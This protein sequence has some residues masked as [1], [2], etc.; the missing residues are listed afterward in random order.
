MQRILLV[1]GGSGGHV[2]PVIAVA[3][4]LKER[5]A[6]AGGLDLALLGD[7]NFMRQAAQ[8]NGIKFRSILAGKLRRYFSLLAVLDIFKFPIGF[9]QSLWH[10]F[11]FMP[12]AVFAKGGYVSIMPALVARLYFI[13]LY[14]HES[15]SVPG[16]ANKFLGRLADKIFKTFQISA[17]YFDQKKT[18]LFGNPVRRELLG[19]NKDE[20]AK[21]FNLSTGKKTIFVYGGSQGAQK[22]NNAIL[23]SLV[24]AVGK[25]LQIIHQCGDTQYQD[26]K[27]SIE[28][29]I[30]EGEGQY[31]ELI[32]RNHRLYSFLNLEQARSAYALADV[33]ISRAGA[34]NIF[35]IASVGK[36]AIIIP[37]VDTSGDHQL[38]NAIAFSKSGAVLIE[39]DNLTPHIILSQI[40][41][42]FIPD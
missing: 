16:L 25:D 30:K 36:P 38:N 28:K 26:V 14:I 7:D 29:L 4:A 19:G 21:L 32:A 18:V 37:I 10:V 33:I 1:G 35:E 6:N 41:Y 23:E 24:M 27:K 20:A 9:L 3:N 13:P 5:S 34:S 15:D 11:W 31:G 39:E 12:D 2:Y 40:E 8:E 42:L 17:E 22:I